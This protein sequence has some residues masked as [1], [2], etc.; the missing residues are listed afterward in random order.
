MS[1]VF[2]GH[3]RRRPTNPDGT[4]PV[5]PTVAKSMTRPRSESPQALRK[6]P[7][8]KREIEKRP[9]RDHGKPKTPPGAGPGEKKEDRK[10]R[11]RITRHAENKGGA[12]DK[13]PIE[14]DP[15][16]VG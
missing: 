16:R 5:P 6:S 4:A 10:E 7:G 14:R 11:Q 1:S 15:N 9:D 8:I 13:Q 2:G 12:T 3:S